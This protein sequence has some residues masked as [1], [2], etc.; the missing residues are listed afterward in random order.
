MNNSPSINTK[1]SR[2][3]PIIKNRRHYH[4]VISSPP[5]TPLQL[6][7][8]SSF[9]INNTINSTTNSPL[10]SFMINQNNS[11]AS[12]N[13]DDKMKN[14]INNSIDTNSY[15]DPDLLPP[16]TKRML[17]TLQNNLPE[18]YLDTS[19]SIYVIRILRYYYYY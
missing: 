6:S 9:A 4:D 12:P 14:T 19:Q 3:S 7:P 10:T 1:P 2:S 15:I 18:R 16:K 8:L 13:I 17:K 11:P 5:S